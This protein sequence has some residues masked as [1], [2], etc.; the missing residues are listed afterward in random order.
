M[1]NRK[2][3]NFVAVVVVVVGHSNFYSSNRA[4]TIAPVLL[5]DHNSLIQN[6]GNRI[7]W[8]GME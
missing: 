4:E 5:Y 2:G 6:R 1:V 7:E 8:N 3:E